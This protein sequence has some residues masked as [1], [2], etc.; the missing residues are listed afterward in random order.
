MVGETIERELAKFVKWRRLLTIVEVW[1]GVMS[2]PRDLQSDRGYKVVVVLI[3]A[4]LNLN[5]HPPETWRV[6]HP[7]AVRA[8]EVVLAG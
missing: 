4:R 1:A 8:A 7:R 2:K 5:P 6:R 3:W